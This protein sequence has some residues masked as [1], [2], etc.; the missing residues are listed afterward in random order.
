MNESGE[1]PSARIIVRR[2]G[3]WIGMLRTF[4]LYVDDQKMGSIPNGH[5]ETF[6]VPAGRHKID[7]TG[8]LWSK[9]EILDVDIQPG[10]TL[11]FECGVVTRR[12]Y[13]FLAIYLGWN[14]ASPAI[15]H[16]PG[17]VW[18]GLGISAMIMLM[19]IFYFA[20]TF[21]RGCMYYLREIEGTKI[22][23]REPA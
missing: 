13:L 15:R 10:Q 4:K 17:G 9:T 6:T 12:L 14:L 23:S 8:A 19:W 7:M 11:T 2:K 20:L 18:V 1:A 3:C 5:E 16:M 21:K 22:N